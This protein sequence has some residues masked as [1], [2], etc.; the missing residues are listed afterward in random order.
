MKAL[1]E[2][3]AKALELRKLGWSYSAIKDELKV[4][5]ASLSLWLHNYPLSERQIRQLSP[6]SRER[7]IEHFR[8]TFR[9]KR[10]NIL[11]EAYSIEKDRIEKLS[12]RD[13]N[14]KCNCNTYLLS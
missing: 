10:Q 9:K 6:L 3:H 4:S 2:K 7:R 1:L 5:K 8:E 12:Q 13:L 11:K 14:S